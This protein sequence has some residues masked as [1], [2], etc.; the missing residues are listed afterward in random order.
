M[1]QA[2]LELVHVV[3]IKTPARGMHYFGLNC[4]VFLLVLYLDL[5]LFLCLPLEENE[6][7]LLVSDIMALFLLMKDTNVIWVSSN[8][9]TEPL[10]TVIR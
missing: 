6:S 4:K 1:D 9:P 7:N 3:D 5:L 10:R 2:G 8:P